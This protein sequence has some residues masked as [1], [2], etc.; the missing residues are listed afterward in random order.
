M[1]VR[2]EVRVE[3]EGKG[4]GGSGAVGVAAYLLAELPD[5]VVG[6]RPQPLHRPNAAL[7]G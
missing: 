4:G 3:G 6:V 1:E 5:G 2:V 7:V